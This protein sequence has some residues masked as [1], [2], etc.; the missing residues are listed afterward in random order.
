MFSVVLTR[1][2]QFDFAPALLFIMA[3]HQRCWFAKN[4]LW[5]FS[6]RRQEKSPKEHAPSQPG[7]RLP[8]RRMG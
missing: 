6:L 7:L 1:P 8:L 5:G 3:L 4:F 2:V